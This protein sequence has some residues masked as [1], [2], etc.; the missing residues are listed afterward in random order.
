VELVTT[1]LKRICAKNVLQL[2]LV[3]KVKMTTALAV[4]KRVDCQVCLKITV[5]NHAQAGQPTWQV[6]V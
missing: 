3:A 5:S 4:I 1:K 2:A 6:C